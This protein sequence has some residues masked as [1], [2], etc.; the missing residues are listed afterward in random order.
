VL[1]STNLERCLH[2]CES[3]CR[4]LPMDWYIRL[5]LM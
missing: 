2:I 4:N 3:C 1:C 5:Q